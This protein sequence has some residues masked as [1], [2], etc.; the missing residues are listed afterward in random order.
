MDLMRSLARLLSLLPLAAGLGLLWLALARYRLPYENGRYF[1]AEQGVVYH[2][3]AA[4]VYTIMGVGLTLVGIVVT[5][6]CFRVTRA[7]RASPAHPKTE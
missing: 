7:P 4:L 1:D 3:Q 6:A 2:A 5:L